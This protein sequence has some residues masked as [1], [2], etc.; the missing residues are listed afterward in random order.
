MI[1]YRGGAIALLLLVV[2][3]CASLTAHPETDPLP[4]WNDGPSKQAIVQ[5]VK[6]VTTEG[7]SNI[8]NNM[9]VYTIV[10][11]ES[12]EEAARLFLNHP[13]FTIFSGDGVEIMECLP[14]PEQK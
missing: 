10:K 12:H 9:A 6:R 2:T 14:I 8:R 1:Q 3:G 4:S 11:A 5:F 7:I 13:H